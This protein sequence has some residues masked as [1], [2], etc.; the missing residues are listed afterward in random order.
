MVLQL[1]DRNTVDYVIGVGTAAIAIWK[2]RLICRSLYMGL[3]TYSH[4]IKDTEKL[5][6][7]RSM[8]FLRNNSIF[9]HGLGPVGEEEFMK[10]KSFVKEMFQEFCRVED[11]CFESWMQEMQWVNPLDSK[12]YIG[13]EV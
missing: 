7:I 6:R 10:F 1:S 5:K 8:V 4:R 3:Y 11:I 9:A 13:T 12:Y 2:R